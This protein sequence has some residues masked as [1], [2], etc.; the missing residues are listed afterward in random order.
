[1]D[2]HDYQY[3]SGELLNEKIRS[4]PRAV[5]DEQI[6]QF[7]VQYAHLCQRLEALYTPDRVDQ[8]IRLRPGGL[9]EIDKAITLAGTNNPKELTLLKSFRELNRV[10]QPFMDIYEEQVLE[11]L[12]YMDKEDLRALYATISDQRATTEDVQKNQTIDY[13]Q[14]QNASGT[15]RLTTLMIDGIRRE[16]KDRFGVII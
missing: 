14:A 7:G 6:R 15:L 8:F 12:K 1:M 13:R 9:D 2:I 10:L 4:L 3:L 16:L 5:R 11:D